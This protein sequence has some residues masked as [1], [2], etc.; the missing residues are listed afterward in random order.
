[1]TLTVSVIIPVYNQTQFVGQAIDSVLAQTFTDYEIIVVNDGSTDETTQVLAQ[2]TAHIRVIHQANAGLS[3]ARN[4]GLR[5]AKGEFIAFL[6]ADD[7]WYSTALATLVTYLRHHPTTDLVCGAWDLIDETGSVIKPPNKPSIFQA[8]VRANFLRAIA[9]GNLF[10]VHALLVR[11]KCFECCGTFDPTLKAVE[12]WDLWIRMA[13]HGHTVKMIDVPVAHY[14]RH[15]NCM[16]QDPQR[17]VQASEQVLQRLFTNQ[18]FTRELADLRDHAYIQMW[19]IIAKY[20]QEG[21]LH[22]DRHRYVEMAQELYGKA[23]RNKQ[24]DQL[25]LS[26]L[27]LLPETEH[28]KRMII[29]ASPDTMIY[30]YWLRGRQLFRDGNYGLML[31]RLKPKNLRPFILGLKDAL[32]ERIKRL[33]V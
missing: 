11:R 32:W 8:R 23:P 16:T 33:R 13:M 31:E 20:C 29:A 3:A 1:M 28:F 4:S 9:T 10:L 26:S 15:S 5:V 24:L 6:D 12:D 30:Y 27:F 21:N 2:Y 19:L 22:A 25:H 7:L 18:Q 14:R 17:M